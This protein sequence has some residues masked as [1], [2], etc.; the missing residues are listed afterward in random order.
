MSDFART[1]RVQ[2]SMVVVVDLDAWETEYG[3]AGEETLDQVLT[4]LRDH[5]YHLPDRKWDGLIRIDRL[6]A[7]QRD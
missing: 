3:T 1:A 6:T 2:V 5:G 4:D 7:A